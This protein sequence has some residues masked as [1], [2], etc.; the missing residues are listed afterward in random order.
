MYIDFEGPDG[1]VH[2]PIATTHDAF[3]VH[4]PNATD[5][6]SKFKGILE[7][8]YKINPLEA[9]EH[10]LGGKGYDPKERNI[11]LKQAKNMLS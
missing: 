8:L 7:E 11:D 2:Y 9:V 5:L 4:A 10:Q 1:R 3:H 6:I